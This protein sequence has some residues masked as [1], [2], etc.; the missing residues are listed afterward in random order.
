MISVKNLTRKYGDFT[1]VNS[2]SFDIPKGQI[3]GLLGHNGAGKTTT[4]KMMTGYLEPTAGK[5][6]VDGQDIAEDRIA[7]QQKIGYLPEQSPL[8]ADMTVWQYLEYVA[9]LRGI[10]EDRQVD[11]I[12][13]AVTATDIGSKA[14]NRIDTLSKGFRQRV[15]VAQA[16]IH[17]PEILILDEP[18]NGLDPTQILAMRRLIKDLAKDATVIISTHIMQEVEAVCDRALIVLNGKL[19]VDS[20]LEDLQNVNNI[21]LAVNQPYEVVRP[22]VDGVSGIEGSEH[23]E[24]TDGVSHLRLT[25]DSDEKSDLTPVVARAVFEKG[26]DL[27]HI[28]REHR[29]LETVFKEV[30]RSQGGVHV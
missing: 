8:Y 6:V 10:H 4:L 5:V 3:I 11:A 14:A 28:H 21:T 12:K 2:V 27:Y 25:L 30:N 7:V 20:S 26:W 16:I 18:T 1:A 24:T 22:V 9:R 23:I 17:R 13:M 29:N 15:G 19:V